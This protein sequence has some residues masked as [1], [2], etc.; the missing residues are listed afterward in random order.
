MSKTKK[1]I[2]PYCGAEMNQHAEKLIEPTTLE[3]ANTMDPDIGAL[4]R[5]FH[6]CP[7][8]GRGAERVGS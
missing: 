3:E 1:M 8:C 7:N 4:V 2:C 6:S 5:E